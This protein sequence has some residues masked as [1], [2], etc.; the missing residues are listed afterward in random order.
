MAFNGKLGTPMLEAEFLSEVRALRYEW[1]GP[2]LRTYQRIDG[3]LR[4]VC[5]ICAVA[6]RIHGGTLTLEALP[7]AWTLGMPS[8]VTVEIMAAADTLKGYDPGVRTRLL[9]ACGVQA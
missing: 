6:N 2:T 5:P 4:E 8:D 9:K 7:A 1:R 3:W